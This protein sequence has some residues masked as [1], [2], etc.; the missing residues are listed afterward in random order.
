M[1]AA[2]WRPNLKTDCLHPENSLTPREQEK[3][4][5]TA[6]HLR[7]LASKLKAR[8][9]SLARS[10]SVRMERWKHKLAGHTIGPDPV[11]QDSV[12]NSDQCG[13]TENHPRQ[14][15]TSFTS[16]CSKPSG[17]GTGKRNNDSAQFQSAQF[18]TNIP[19]VFW[20]NSRCKFGILSKQKHASSNGA[21]VPNEKGGSTC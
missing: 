1:K 16:K 20:A 14:T 10:A 18:S 12:L 5:V 7:H 8:A 19:L 6:I 15:Y 13:G 9:P 21:R 2:D 3:S 11:L 17:N 4:K